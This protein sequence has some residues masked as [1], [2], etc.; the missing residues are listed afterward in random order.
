MFVKKI[1]PSGQIEHINWHDHYVHL[2]SSAGIEFP[3]VTPYSSLSQNG[4]G[5]ILEK[6]QGRGQNI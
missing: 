5:T 4:R 6:P 3:G 2:R 1:S